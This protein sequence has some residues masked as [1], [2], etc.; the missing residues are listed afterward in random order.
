MY[1]KTIKYTDY[2]DN[3]REETFLFNLSKAELLEMEMMQDGGLTTYIQRIIDAQNIP[4]LTK[5][6]KELLFKSFGVKSDD[7]KRF[8]KS[9]ELSKEFSETEAYSDLYMELA[10]DANAASEF[11]NNIMPKKLREDVAEMI[12]KNPNLKIAG[13]PEGVASNV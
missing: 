7:G 10:T 9:P 3:E 4:E 6:F 13:I 8:M 12:K 5:L 1:S 11:I 2:N